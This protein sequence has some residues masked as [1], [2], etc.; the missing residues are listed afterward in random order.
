M[1]HGN[2]TLKN[3]I[4][5]MNN[6][7]SITVHQGG[8]RCHTTYQ[9]SGKEFTSDVSAAMGGAGEHPSPAAMLAASVASCMLSMIG[10]LGQNKGFDTTGISIAAGFTEEKGVISALHFD[11]TVPMALTAPQQRMLEGAVKSCPVGNAIAPTV[12]KDIHWNF[13]A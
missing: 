13:S 10:W 2:M 5:A 11:I 7:T 1:A 8:I 4:P 9:P 3:S 6:P 12:Q